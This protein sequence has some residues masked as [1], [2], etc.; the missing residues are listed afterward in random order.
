MMPVCDFTRGA[1]CLQAAAPE[2]LVWRPE[3][4]PESRTH[5]DIGAFDSCPSHHETVLRTVLTGG[6]P[7][8]RPPP[9]RVHHR[10]DL[11]TGGEGANTEWQEEEKQLMD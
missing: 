1:T 8:Q 11:G 3:S 2:R 10:V 7:G 5:A 6:D 9:R 4:E